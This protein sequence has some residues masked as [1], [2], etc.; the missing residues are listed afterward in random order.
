MDCNRLHPACDGFSPLVKLGV[1]FI[2]GGTRIAASPD[3]QLNAAQE[4]DVG[5]IIELISVAGG[6]VSNQEPDRP[7]LFGR[8]RL[9][10]A[11]GYRETPRPGRLQWDR[12]REIL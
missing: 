10:G 2:S 6:G 7:A 12:G 4:L 9:G 3:G 11:V 5:A 1:I 8:Q